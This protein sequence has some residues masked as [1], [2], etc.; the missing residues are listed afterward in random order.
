MS[1]LF[2][3]ALP[4]GSVRLARGDATS[5]PASLVADGVEV[6][7]L[8][9]GGDD[10]PGDALTAALGAPGAGELPAGWQPLA[11]LGSQEVWA[12]GVTFERSRTARNEEAGEVDIYDRVYAAARPELF[13][14][15]APG[16]VRGPGQQV[17]IRRDS[18]WDVPEPEL[19]LVA[20]AAGRL[21]ALT[22]GNDMSS[23]SIEGENPLYLP[24]AKLFTASCAVGPAL[25]PL[26][27]AP[28]L[29]TLVIEMAIHRD[30]R[31]LFSDSV[32]LSSMRRRPEELLEWLFWAL[33]FPVGVVL[34]TGTSI[35]PPPEL[36][37]RAGDVVD[38]SVRGLGSLSNP[39]TEV[40]RPM[41]RELSEVTA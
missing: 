34:L 41:P 11:P 26:V 36:T 7:Q 18:G 35:V 6:D 37:L 22:I 30:H 3:V 4:D 19:G 17:G 14:K 39:V 23:R 2:K 12:S 8:L 13:L 20:D 29:D 27:D 33:E 5:G 9:A 16:R 31:V 38:I 15:A 28:P 25:V 21:V 32:P 1:A 10:P 24:Q 40:G